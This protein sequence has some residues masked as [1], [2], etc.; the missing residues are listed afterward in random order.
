MQSNDFRTCRSVC[1]SGVP[2]PRS[3]VVPG[4]EE[5]G[6]TMETLEHIAFDRRLDVLIWFTGRA[7]AISAAA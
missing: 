7:P 4:K 5:Q 3:G 1:V 6:S 2:A